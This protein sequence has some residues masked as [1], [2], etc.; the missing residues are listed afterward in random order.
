MIKTRTYFYLI[1]F[2]IILMGFSSGDEKI[3]KSAV[4]EVQSDLRQSMKGLK[5]DGSKVTY[6]E[7]KRQAQFKEVEVVLFLRENNHLYFNGDLSP[8]RVSLKIYDG[9]ANGEE[10]WLLY[11]VRNIANKTVSVSEDEMIE[12][13][14]FY[15]PSVKKL[16]SVYVDY[17]ISR[18]RNSER[19]AVVM[20][21]GFEDK[22][23]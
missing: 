20:S 19:G 4:R 21:I 23:N 6:F 11:E 5:Y 18:S 8:S 15:D 22:K 16:R 7:T 13:L 3:T 9:P 14:R 10:R 12:R 17:E 1:V 2:S